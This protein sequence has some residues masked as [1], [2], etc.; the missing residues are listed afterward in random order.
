MK[1]K[2]DKIIEFGNNIII[3]S[4][5]TWNLSPNKLMEKL[6]WGFYDVAL[7]NNALV[8]PVLT[9]KVGKKCYSRVLKPIDLK[10]ISFEEIEEIYIAMQKY[11]NKAYDLIIYDDIPSNKAKQIIISLKESIKNLSMCKTIDEAKQQIDYIQL[12]CEQSSNQINELKANI[13]SNEELEISAFN[14][15]SKLI[16]RVGMAKKEVMVTKVRDTMALEKYDMIE[17][18][19][20]YS[21][22]KNGKNMYEA[23]DDYIKDTISATPYFYPEPEATTVFKDP[24]IKDEEEVMPWLN[25]QQ[26][27]RKI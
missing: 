11:I 16:F 22:M 18:N 23:W 1:N 21:Y 12:C 25:K 24:M 6:H 19:P 14:L 17:K 20:D 26:K 9:H 15:V 2:M 3:F 27:I 5:A 8:V 10:E 4:E 7:K 13:D